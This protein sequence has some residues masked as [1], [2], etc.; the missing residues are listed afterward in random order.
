MATYANVRLKSRRE[1]AVGTMAF[2]FE[3]PEGFQF[4]AG[5]FV[6]LALIDPPETDTKGNR[7]T[8]SIAS[9]PYEQDLIVVTRMRDTAFK[10][11]L[12]TMP[13]GTA[14][15]IQGPFGSLTLE[16]NPSRPVV[17][18]AGGIGI[19]PFR[20]MILQGT[21]DPQ[22][23]PLFLFYS[24]RRPVDGPFLAELGELEKRNPQYRFI[25]TITEIEGRTWQGERGYITKEMLARYINDLK[26][27]VYYIAGP[28]TMVAAMHKMLNE[29]GVNT[30]SIHTEEFAGY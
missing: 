14:V 17:M 11:I 9:A 13:L 23:Q 29:A 4:K 2:H 28:E 25:G 19:T 6:N 10:R 21:Q 30:E 18:L 1:I 27:P 15:K 26:A 20:S 3:K 8:F 24:N 12:K 16:E 22:A 5:Q 7:R